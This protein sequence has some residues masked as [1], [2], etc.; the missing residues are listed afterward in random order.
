MCLSTLSHVSVQIPPIVSRRIVG[1]HVRFQNESKAVQEELFRRSS[2]SSEDPWHASRLTV[3][4]PDKS[5]PRERASELQVDKARDTHRC[6]AR[7]YFE[8]LLY[9]IT[10]VAAV[11]VANVPK[12]HP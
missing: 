1:F 5:L 8:A 9:L 4:L 3:T 11:N 12:S 2:C 6:N 7:T 10:E